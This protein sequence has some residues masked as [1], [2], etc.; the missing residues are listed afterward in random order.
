M[1]FEIIDLHCDTIMDCHFNGVKLKD[2]EGHINIEKLRQGN[3]MAQALALF[4]P[5]D[6]KV[7]RD[8]ITLPWDIYKGMLSSWKENVDA[9]SD[10]IRPAYSASDI[11]KNAADGYMSA[12]LT[13]EDGIGIDDKMQRLEEMYDDG[14]RMLT[15]T[16]NWE[17]CIGY[18]NSS[19]SDEHS[20][21]LKPFGFG[22]VE[23]MNEL[24]MVIDVSHLSEGGFWDVATASKYPF[25]ASHSCA[26]KLHDHQ[27]NLTDKQLRALADHGGV[28]GINFCS[29]FLSDDL[30]NSYAEDVI[31][32][33]LHFKDVCG[34]DSI[35]WG[36]DFDG[37]ES[38]LDFKDYTGM[39]RLVQMLEKYFTDDEIDKI[40]HGN[41]LRVFKDS[42]K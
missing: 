20:K 34:V 37:I 24:G 23:R 15:L 8:G 3:C 38:N 22:V 35:A 14:V 30:R 9:N 12:L 1:S 4:I 31:K 25:V 5:T 26:R 21:G 18:P 11:E 27:R 10:S 42:M 2:R 29:A 41:A 36:S 17:N 19:D 16:W 28:V 13:V 40:N 39:P 33:M 32:H 7:G 6:G